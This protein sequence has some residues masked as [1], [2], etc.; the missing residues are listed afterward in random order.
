MICTNCGHSNEEKPVKD[1]WVMYQIKNGKVI[2]ALF[3]P[4]N[5]P[6]G[7]FDSPRAALAA[8]E[9]KASQESIVNDPGLTISSK[10][11]AK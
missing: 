2:N 5:T 11:K 4:D 3:C 9:S 7:W 6:P 1:K 10:K 8:K